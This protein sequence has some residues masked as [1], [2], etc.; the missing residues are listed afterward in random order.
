MPHVDRRSAAL[1]SVRDGRRDACAGL[2]STF[3]EHLTTRIR[4]I[5]DEVAH[6]PRPIARCDVQ[7][8][9][10]LEER[11]RVYR[12][13]NLATEMGNPMPPGG[14]D[15]HWLQRLDEY[16]AKLEPCGDD[17]VEGDLRARLVK[18]MAQMRS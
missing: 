5:N 6:Y 13:L 17:D 9:K 2:W 16:L 11:A 7:L 8:S 15:G 1:A 3:L 4:E 18:S 10:L 14:D 12:Q